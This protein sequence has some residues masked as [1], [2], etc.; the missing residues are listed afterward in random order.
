MT[1]NLCLW[2]LK[3][4]NYIVHFLLILFEVSLQDKFLFNGLVPTGFM[5][6]NGNI[7]C[8]CKYDSND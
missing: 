3:T 5:P 1:A 6:R 7:N 4:S 2:N 8:N